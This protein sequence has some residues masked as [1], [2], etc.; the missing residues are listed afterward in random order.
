MFRQALEV[1]PTH[2]VLLSNAGYFFAV[3]RQNPKEA[4][5]VLRLCVDR[6]PDDLQAICNLAYVLGTHSEET[7]QA[8]AL[9]N[10]AIE[11]DPLDAHALGNYGGFQLSL[12]NQTEGLTLVHNALDLHAN[13]C[14]DSRLACEFFV[15]AHGTKVDRFPRLLNIASLIRAGVTTVGWNFS[16]NIERAVADGFSPKTWLRK[17]GLVVCGQEN[18]SCLL[19]W[20]EWQKANRQLD[21]VEVDQR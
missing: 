11:L 2:S 9:Y 6:Y 8:E 20:S 14:A 1:D 16:K 10:R 13:E 15:F 4:A 5:R 12:G 3:H 7:D 18:V 21:E 17:L 19:A